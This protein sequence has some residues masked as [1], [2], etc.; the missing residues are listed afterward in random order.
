VVKA[1]TPSCGDT[2]ATCRGSDSVC[3]TGTCPM[4]RG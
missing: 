2:S 4:S 1:E 3:A